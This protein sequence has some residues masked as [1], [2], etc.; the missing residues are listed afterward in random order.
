MRVVVAAAAIPL[1]HLHY[2]PFSTTLKGWLFGA[3]AQKIDD[4][5]AA[6]FCKNSRIQTWRNLCA[7]FKACQGFVSSNE[8]EWQRL[9]QASVSN[10]CGAILPPKEQM[11]TCSLLTKSQGLLKEAWICQ[12]PGRKTSLGWILCNLIQGSHTVHTWDLSVHFAFSV[13]QS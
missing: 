6:L 12:I 2:V 7:A 1:S 4:M 8:N 3:A 10:E 11:C 9:Y 5:K 13:Q